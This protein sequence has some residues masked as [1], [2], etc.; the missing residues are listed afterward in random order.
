M[1]SSLQQ[2][3]DVL[4]QSSYML[5]QVESQVNHI[6]FHLEKLKYLICACE[7]AVT[8]SIWFD[9]LSTLEDPVELWDNFKHETH[10]EF[11]RECSRSRDGFVSEEI[12]TNIKE[13]HF[14]VCREPGLI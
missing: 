1:Q 10:L 13:S 6:V 5:S 2:T 8:V 14:W 3:I 4:L 9:G 7:Y 12:L 11:I